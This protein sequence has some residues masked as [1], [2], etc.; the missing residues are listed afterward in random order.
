MPKV[1]PLC[2]G[3]AVRVEEQAALRCTGIEYPAKLY[4][5]LVHFGS[6]EALNTDGL[7]E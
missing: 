6:R 3:E 5:K 1:W 2:G 4:R 7:G